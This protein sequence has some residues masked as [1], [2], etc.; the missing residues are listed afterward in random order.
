MPTYDYTCANGHITSDRRPYAQA[1]DHLT[2]CLDCGEPVRQ[3]LHMPPVF[4]RRLGWRAYHPD[5]AAKGETAREEI[6]VSE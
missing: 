4:Y 6:C 1:A 3:V 5:D 2:T